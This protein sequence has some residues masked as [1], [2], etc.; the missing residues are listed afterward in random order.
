MKSP[1]VHQ[2]AN[3]QES[4][5][6]NFPQGKSMMP[7]QFSLSSSSGNV[8]TLGFGNMWDQAFGPIGLGS[9][10]QS[11]ESA[12]KSSE[13]A[14]GGADSEWVTFAEQ[15]NNRFKS[16][17]HV[18]EPEGTPA[19][20]VEKSVA[21]GKVLTPE[22]CESLFTKGQRDKLIPFFQTNVIPERLFNGDERGKTTAAQRILLSA[23]ILANGIYAPG[24]F[25]QR[26]HAKNCGHWAQTVQNYAG[27][28]ANSGANADSLNGN[29][30]L[31]GN[32][33]LGAEMA[34][35]QGFDEKRVSIENLP[36]EESATIGPIY[37]GTA[38]GEEAAKRANR[39]AELEQ[40]DAN[41]PDGEKSKK[42]LTPFRCEHLSM[43]LFDTVKPG[44]WLYIYNANGSGNHSVIFSRW[45]SGDLVVDGGI[46]YRKAV[47]FDQNKPVA[48]GEE[49]NLNLGQQ[50]HRTKD[51]QICPIT[52]VS[53]VNPEQRPA[54]SIEELL[55]TRGDQ[56][57]LLNEKNQKFIEEIK[58]QSGG[59]IT[60][61]LLINLLVKENIG[62]IDALGDRLSPEQH[63]MLTD[64]NNVKC[65]L[66]TLVRLTERL[67]QLHTNADL[68]AKNEAKIYESKLNGQ[69]AEL[70]TAYKAQEAEINALIEPLE[71]EK[72][73]WEEELAG[74]TKDRDELD[75]Y[76]ELSLARKKY[77]K[78]LAELKLMGKS[79]PN[80]DAKKAERDNI[81]AE[82]G[83]WKAKGK[84]N[85]GALGES[86]TEINSLRRKIGKV[87]AKISK[88]EVKLEEAALLLP[89][90]QV[91]GGS[92]KE[93]DKTSNKAG[94]TG[95]LEST[96]GEAAIKDLKKKAKA[97][98]F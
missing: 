5:E 15:F 79:D 90:G 59:K 63:E 78:V 91:A 94:K 74:L 81:L 87:N 28:T 71:K 46:Q 24:S 14:Q 95:T 4:S 21:S 52:K 3:K 96:L 88:L 53:K 41:N 77:R 32:V 12:E 35:P 7:P 18:F 6:S 1:L 38:H 69:Y 54:E 29:F 26:V 67:R 37:E 57:D 10:N 89:W 30:D 75:T 31:H 34:K 8:G 65:D 44:D 93:Q 84:A 45:A 70:I 42:P 47:T 39:R 82:I 20:F 61:D 62:H 33:I 80:R 58:K 9:K 72:A 11:T 2:P 13:H 76:P 64:A 97:G 48:G 40:Q 92:T 23:E 27:V 83:E 43:D 68:L 19:N 98:E 73:P 49:H 51:I 60:E 50:F 66:E 22:Q 55:P 85:K 17:L 86:R 56:D 16:V 36:E 25:E